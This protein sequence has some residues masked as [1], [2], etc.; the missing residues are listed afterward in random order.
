M[1]AVTWRARVRHTRLVARTVGDELVW[2]ALIAL[3][4][5]RGPSPRRIARAATGS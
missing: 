2:V 5:R 3:A 4:R 1:A